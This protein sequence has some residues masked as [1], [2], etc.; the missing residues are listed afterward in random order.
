MP[1]RVCSE[2][3]FRNPKKQQRSAAD[4]CAARLQ[5]GRV[6]AATLLC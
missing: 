3:L 1:P 5:R 4:D 2:I 6:V